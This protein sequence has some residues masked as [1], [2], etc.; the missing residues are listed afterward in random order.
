MQ[1]PLVSVRLMVYNNE[2]YI[3]EAVESILMQQT[4]FKVEIVV[5]D[6]FSTDNTLEIIKSYANTENIY[7]NILDRPV[8]GAYWKDRQ[9]LG[10]LYNFKNIIDN[11]SGKYIALLDGDDYWTDP[12]K[13]Q[14]QVDFLES[15]NGFNYC[16][17]NSYSLKGEEL[18]EI[19]LNVQEIS[20]EKLIF[21][22]VLN[23]GTLVFRANSF[24]LP[25]YFVSLE[26]GDWAIQLF[27]IK[28]SKAFV[29][30]DF[31]SAYRIHEESLWNTISKKD[32]CLKGVKLQKGMKKFYK[33]KDSQNI[34]DKAI[35]ERK[36]KFGIKK[37]TFLSR[38]KTKIN[39][40]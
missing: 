26:T 2:P 13:L 4:N 15:N 35:L 21:K 19:K 36:R 7:F 37:N 23:S 12:L 40:N 3:R 32:M 22:N 6:D 17:H 14:K 38:L 25:D 30:K 5:G 8:E 20:F 33:D 31:M 18:E 16:A 11:C 29:L 1:N 9:K 10:R 34:I 39:F 24:S 27:S 28:N